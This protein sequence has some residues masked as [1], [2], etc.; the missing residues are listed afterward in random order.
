MQ[1]KKLNMTLNEARRYA[2][3]AQ[4][5]QYV[6]AGL[7]E[8]LAYFGVHTDYADFD[9]DRLSVTSLF[10]YNFQSDEVATAEI[11]SFDGVEFL[12]A[13]KYGD[14]SDWLTSYLN[15]D[16]FKQFVR[17]MTELQ[18][19]TKLG[20]VGD[21]T[22]SGDFALGGPGHPFNGYI[23]HSYDDQSV[24]VH[25]MSPKWGNFQW[26]FRTHRAEY[27]G[28]PVEFVGWVD[29]RNSWEIKDTEPDVILRFPDGSER[30]VEGWRVR[31]I[32][33]SQEKT[34]AA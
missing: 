26:K 1:L 15:L 12:L 7:S 9:T 13:E 22:V 19:N 30:P 11:Y 10:Q 18:L 16:V 29:N 28:E 4:T 34:D 31:F 8:E 2:Q 20:I 23:A 5:C 33:K 6:P 24:A 21:Q 27:D 3:P 32:L 17:F 25:F 14:K